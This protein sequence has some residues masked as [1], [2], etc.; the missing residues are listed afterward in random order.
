MIDLFLDFFC[1]VCLKLRLFLEI[2]SL[3]HQ[4]QDNIDREVI[5]AEGW[6]P[7]QSNDWPLLLLH[8]FANNEQF[9]VTLR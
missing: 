2:F 6:Q 3:R 1:L 5:G 4:A 8:L 9:G 7:S